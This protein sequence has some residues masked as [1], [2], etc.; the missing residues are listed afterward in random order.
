MA[1]EKPPA[2]AA[3]T[4]GAAAEAETQA[5]AAPAPAA[6]PAAARVAEKPPAP[7]AAPVA[8]KPVP[9]PRKVAA[10]TVS[11]WSEAAF[12]QA[13]HA[14]T[15]EAGTPVEDLLNPAFYANIAGKMN[16]GDIVE[17]RPADGAYYLELYVWDRG[18]NW[19]Q[20]GVLRALERP[21]PVA[22]PSTDDAFLIEFVDGAKK[23][24]VLRKSDKAEVAH[25]FATVAAANAWLEHNRGKLAA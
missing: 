23:H 12:K 18:D 24:R 21:G 22:V 11:R 3:A 4:S 10:L 15:P 14:I 19:A 1:K 13:R 16:A 25:G 20:V 2:P 9:A 17:A 8:D 7:A 5:A 6:P